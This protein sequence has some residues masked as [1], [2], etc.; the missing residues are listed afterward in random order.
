MNIKKFFKWP[1][2]IYMFWLASFVMGI[3]L[4]GPILLIFFKDW[5]GLTQT[6]TQML[7][8]WFMISIFILEVPTGILGDVKGK[9]FS[10]I[11]GYAF[12]IL[13][14]LVYSIIPNLLLFLSA[15]FIFALGVA[16]ISGAEEAWIYD[17]SKKLNIEHKYRE[18]S[19]TQSNMAMLGMI[20]A[21][22]LFIPLSKIFPVQHIF[23]FKIVSTTLALLLLAIFVP[24]TDDNT[25]KSLKP[26]YIGTA[27][28]GFELF[29]ENATLRMLTLYLS[30]LGTTSYFVI[31]LYQEA[32][33]VLNQPNEM[34]GLYRI[35]LLTAE[36]LMG[37]LGTI[38]INRCKSK[39][40]LPFIALIV[41]TGFLLV[42][43]LQTILGVLVFLILSGGLGLQIHSLLSKELNEEIDSDERA[44]ILS[45]TSM[46]KRLMLTIFNPL[47]GLLVDN[48]GVFIAFGVLGVISFLAI[49]SRPKFKLK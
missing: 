19:V 49:F 31:W 9:K 38:L 16:F 5:G 24:S 42:S 2:E 18:I 44:T 30:L 35:V 26:D 46:I 33:E 40:V 27:K 48:N 39:R 7:Q 3:D 28:R 17:T 47:I 29:K 1:K 6:Q 12:L 11:T 22:I 21:A 45:F 20:V 4:I 36:I 13:G 41:A 34:Y 32:L 25:K 23:K 37:L 14:T 15:E 8:S 43:I 10:V